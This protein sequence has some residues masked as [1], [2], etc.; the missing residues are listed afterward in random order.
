MMNKILLVFAFL[1]AWQGTVS[2]LAQDRPWAEARFTNPECPSRPYIGYFGPSGW[3]LD[4]RTSGFR[5]TPAQWVEPNDAGGTVAVPLRDGTTRRGTIPGAYCYQSDA[6]ASINRPDS[7]FARLSGMIG[8]ASDGDTISLSTFSFSERRIAALLCEAMGRGVRVSIVHGTDSASVNAL[9]GQG[10]S[11]CAQGRADVTFGGSENGG[12]L[13]HSKYLLVES[14]SK[15]TASL[16]FQSANFTSGVSLHHENWVFTEST[17][18]DP[19]IIAHRCHFRALKTTHFNNPSFGG[20]EAFRVAMTECQN[21][22]LTATDPSAATK[23]LSIQ[24]YFVPAAQGLRPDGRQAQDDLVNA[25]RQADAID[26]I[27]HHLTFK[28]LLGAL[29]E[30]LRNGKKVRILMDDEIFWVGNSAIAR[31]NDTDL[32]YPDAGGQPVL[33][34][35]TGV[36]PFDHY[37]TVALFVRGCSRGASFSL[38]EYNALLPVLKAGAEIR[39]IEANHRDSL[40]Q[41][42]KFVV[43]LAQGRPQA[44]FTGA[45]NLSEAAFSRNGENFYLIKEPNLV[46]SFAKQY[47]HLWSKLAT[48]PEKLP[49]TWAIAVDG[50]ASWPRWRTA[51]EKTKANCRSDR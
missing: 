30:A 33:R 21:Q 1:V 16:S 42:N 6:E 31:Q 41:H 34:D 23:T 28:P 26:V 10:N 47:D 46:H 9:A 13:Q 35:G 37:P 25:I 20:V 8:E 17:L 27:S 24:P 49:V 12:R 48:P 18:Q 11:A 44:V 22:E 4:P 29:V 38:D 19:F 39:Y 2:A 15:G 3:G 40:F 5:F 51:I 45:G 7:V 36:S 50:D 14:S 43:T 32:L